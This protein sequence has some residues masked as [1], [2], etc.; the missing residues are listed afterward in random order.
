MSVTPASVRGIHTAI[1]TP[2]ADGPDQPV[3]HATL[4]RLIERQLAG[5]IH[6]I[7][8]CG[9]TGEAPTLANDE[10]AAVVSTA[11]RVARGK[12]VVTA[13]VGTNNTRTTVAATARAAELGADIGLLVFP[14]YNRPNPDGLRAHV[15]AAAKVGLP[16]ML[17]HVPTRTGQ[18]LTHELLGEL[19]GID[20]VVGV[21]EATG[22]LRYGT[23]LMA[24]TDRPVLSGDD[25]T[26]LGLLGQGGVGCVSVLSNVAPAETVAIYDAFVAGRSADALAGLRKLWALLTFLFADASPAPTK[27]AL[28]ALGL[29]TTSVRGP[30]APHRGALPI[31]LVRKALA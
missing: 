1:V 10:W 31:E 7:V 15:A 16:L 13:G 8:A 24:C 27:A 25:F 18:R 23:D 26:F 2:F 12:A 4:E 14:Y 3:D 17:Y 11:V 5:G 19:M 9:T 30:I 20:G 28:A 6:G 22:D 29:C 21:K